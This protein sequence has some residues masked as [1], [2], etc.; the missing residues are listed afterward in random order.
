MNFIKQIE[1][2]QDRELKEKWNNIS[3][4]ALFDTALEIAKLIRKGD[5]T[6]VV[7]KR[8][9]VKYVQLLAQPFDFRLITKRETNGTWEG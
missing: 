1:R 9:I 8:L 6:N 3:T 4:I 7:E 5:E 2:I